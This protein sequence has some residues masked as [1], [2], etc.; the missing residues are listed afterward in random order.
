MITFVGVLPKKTP[1]ELLI[2]LNVISTSPCMEAGLVV[3]SPVAFSFTI[4]ILHFPT[5][6]GMSIESFRL[7]E[8]MVKPQMQTKNSSFFISSSF[9]TCLK[10]EMLQMNYKYF[11]RKIS[12]K[13]QYT[14][15]PRGVFA[16]NLKKF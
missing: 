10:I 6:P 3:A 16:A 9:K 11:R 12:K 8:R 2:D 13:S 7:Q 5:N 4:T 14:M 1:L 15:C